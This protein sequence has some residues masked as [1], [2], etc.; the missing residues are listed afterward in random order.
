L[1]IVHN[2]KSKQVCG[3]LHANYQ[4]AAAE[5]I[6]ESQVPS[7]KSNLAYVR[8]MSALLTYPTPPTLQ[9]LLLLSHSRKAVRE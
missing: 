1:S 6:G 7:V 3:R 5:G 9:D 2:I 4:A 8:F